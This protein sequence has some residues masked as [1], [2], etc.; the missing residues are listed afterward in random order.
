MRIKVNN[1]LTG[2]KIITTSVKEEEIN[3]NTLPGIINSAMP[4]HL[5]NK[6]D[7]NMLLDIYKGEQ[8]ILNRK[9]EVRPEINNK[10]VINNAQ[11]ITRTIL[12]Y[13]LGTPI[14]I[15]Q[16]TVNKDAEVEKLKDSIDVESIDHVNYDVGEYQSVCGTGYKMTYVDS[17]SDKDE[18]PFEQVSLDPRNTFVIYSQ[19]VRHKPLVGVTYHGV[20]NANGAVDKIQYYAY[21]KN[22]VYRY[23][24]K[25]AAEGNIVAEELQEGYPKTHLLGGVPIVEYPNNQF[26]IGDF[27]PALSVMNAI[28]ENI[29]DRMN[30]LEQFVQSLLVFYNVEIDKERFAEMRED[31]AIMVKS[32]SGQGK[33][34][35]V[36]YIGQATNQSEIQTLTDY[37]TETMNDLVGIPDR[38]LRGG[39]GGDTGNAVELR[40]GWAD[41]EIVA[42]NKE[43]QFK[44]S[45]KESLRLVLN[46]LREKDIV[47]LSLTDIDVKFPRNPNNNLLVKTQSLQTLISSKVLAPKDALLICGLSTDTLEM[48]K[49]GEEFWGDEF[50][51]KMNNSAENTESS[52]NTVEDNTEVVEDV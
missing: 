10:I 38:K 28:N 7:E 26:R 29:S 44:K 52:E 21:T 36:D 43:R 9:K 20:L 32:T 22:T 46:I 34:A 11:K 3:E 27:E 40:D 1:V 33:E 6:A 30:D 14:E 4:T 16:R 2:R 50:A 47:D 35:K 49:R 8:P 19:D 45:E 31:G 12:G 39:G 51:G 5:S 23:L 42:R 41:L 17:D 18:T 48:T 15:T 13:F 24:S 37:L 25:N